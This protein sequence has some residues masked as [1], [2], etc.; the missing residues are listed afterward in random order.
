MRQPSITTSWVADEKATR[1]A[2]ATVSPRLDRRV[3]EASRDEPERDADL[4]QQHPAAPPPEEL[5]QHRHVEAI[6][7]GRPEEL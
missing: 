2:A 4:R 7:E 5:R 6:D 3:A 1:K